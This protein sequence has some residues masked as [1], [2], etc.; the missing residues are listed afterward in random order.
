MHIV[1]YKGYVEGIFIMLAN[2]L[3]TWGEKGLRV[4]WVHQRTSRHRLR[5]ASEKAGVTNTLQTQGKIGPR[6]GWGYQTPHI[7][8][9][10][11]AP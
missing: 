8:G 7:H 9:V 2:T 10:T 1:Y 5:K 4:G 6:E 3:K 11:K